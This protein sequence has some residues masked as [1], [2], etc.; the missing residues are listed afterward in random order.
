MEQ[1]KKKIYKIAIDTNATRRLKFVNFLIK[2]KDILEVFL[3]TIVQMEIAYYYISHAMSWKMFIDETLKWGVVHLPFES[4][5]IPQIISTAYSNRGKLS[6]KE[7]FRDYMIGV[8]AES[9]SEEFISYN[10]D[11][12]TWLKIPVLTPEEF[13]EKNFMK[14]N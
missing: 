14:N 1:S 8:Q 7:H 13:I 3:P 9:V 11:H 5:L 2:N 4:N 10:K 6:L 12:F